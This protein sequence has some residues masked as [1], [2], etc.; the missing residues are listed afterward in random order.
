MTLMFPLFY[1]IILG[2]AIGGTISHVPIGMTQVDLFKGESQEFQAT[3]QA[4]KSTDVFDVTLYDNEDTAKLALAEGSVNAVAVFPSPRYDD[5]TIRLYVDSSDSFMPPVIESGITGLVRQLGTTDQILIN[6]I[7]GKVNYLQF[8]GVAILVMSIFMSSMMGGGNAMIRDR[9]NGIIEGYYVTP[10]KRTSI[11]L[12]IIL[13]GTVRSLLAT[14]LLLIV[15]V[16]VAGVIIR[17]LENLLLVVM[18]LVLISFS[19]TSFVVSFASRFPNQQ[20]YASTVGFLNLLL[21]M[22]SGAFYPTI[23]MPYWLRWITV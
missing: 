17:S 1:L 20:T 15:D 12:G 14:F 18:V 8:F 11:L 5:H 16:L 21:F 7:Y 6:E 13:S 4:L 9:E 2:N 23:A 19:I 3:L 22:T 10:V